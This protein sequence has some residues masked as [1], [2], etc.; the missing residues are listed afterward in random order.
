MLSDLK[1]IVTSIAGIITV[2]VSLLATLGVGFAVG[3]TVAPPSGSASTP[4]LTVFHTVT[5]TVPA[6]NA[7]NPP[8]SSSAPGTTNLSALQPVETKGPVG[9]LTTGSE[10]I[11]TQPYPN[12]VRFICNSSGS[13]GS[14]DVVYDVAGFKFLDTT[15]GIPSDSSTAAGN[16]MN[17]TF[18]KDATT[19][20][21][22]PINVV[23]GQPQPVRLDLQGATQLEI[24]CS[25]TSNITHNAA[26]MDVALGSA[27]L[28]SS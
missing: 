23:L 18:L 19:Q 2:I 5:V 14:G 13:T 10:Q 28:G 20:L 27:T 7:V 25:G 21:G 4:P 22:S 16:T 9:S 6:T 8:T 12:S 24:Q 3:H 1:D 15:I 17:I 26:Q 11:G